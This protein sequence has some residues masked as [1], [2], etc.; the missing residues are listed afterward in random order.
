M[1]ASSSEVTTRKASGPIIE[2]GVALYVHC[3]LVAGAFGTMSR[4]APNL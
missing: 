4:E 2:N 3:N 1:S